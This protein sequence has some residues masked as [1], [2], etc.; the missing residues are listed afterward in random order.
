MRSKRRKKPQESCFVSLPARRGE[1]AASC[2]ASVATGSFI[3]AV[4]CMVSFGDFFSAISTP[5]VAIEA[6][7]GLVLPYV[8]SSDSARRGLHSE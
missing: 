7:N 1:H 4:P 2:E 8:I 3:V 6:L 5:T